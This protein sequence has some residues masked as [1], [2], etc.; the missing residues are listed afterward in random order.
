MAAGK[1][2]RGGAVG[3]GGALI[4]VAEIS[5]RRPARAPSIG[6]DTRPGRSRTSR[7]GRGG[8]IGLVAD[9]LVAVAHHLVREIGGKNI[10][11]S[12]SGADDGAMRML[13][14]TRRKVS[15]WRRATR[16]VARM[17]PCTGTGATSTAPAAR[18]HQP[19]LEH[20]AAHGVA[21]H[22][23]RCGQRG[24]R[25]VDV[26][27]VVA[28]P[29]AAQPAR[30]LGAVVAQVERRAPRGLP[31]EAGAPCGPP[32]P[33][34]CQAPWTSRSDAIGA[35]VYPRVRASGSPSRA[36][37]RARLRAGA[38]APGGAAERRREVERIRG[39]ETLTFWSSCR[40]GARPCRCRAGARPGT[41][42]R[43]S[44]RRGCCRSRGAPRPGC[45]RPSRS[46]PW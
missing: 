46:R 35:A 44:I 41:P 15:G 29:A 17:A 31:G 6:L 37:A 22:H 11:G 2:H 10:C 4:S 7:A 28:D 13:A 19:A 30:I 32:A 20:E 45:R 25:G 18:V 21:D 3:P 12:A 34:T 36:R 5:R 39:A 40:S 23:Q 1:H 33:G 38:R 27:D 42:S 14:F 9:A 16:R 8:E 24:R 43:G 26:G